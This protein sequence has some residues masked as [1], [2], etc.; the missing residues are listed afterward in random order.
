MFSRRDF[1][2][3]TSA[4]GLAAALPFS[5]NR[6]TPA[7]RAKRALFVYGGW[8]GHQPEAYRDRMV[9]RLET[10]GFEVTVSDTLDIYADA[11]L[12]GGLDV[13]VQQWT[14][15]EIGRAQ[16][17][18]LLQAVK[19]GVGI[20]GWHGGLGD[21]F[22]ANTDYQYMIG[23]QWV[24]HPGN[25]IDYTVHITDPNDPIT[26]GLS[27]FELKGTEQYYMHVDP[28]NHVLATTRFS[29]AHDPWID[30]AVVPVAW[31]KMFGRGRVFYSSI[32]HNPEDFDVPEVLELTMRG[33]RWAS[34]GR[35]AEPERLIR[36]VYD[37]G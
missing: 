34:E 24:A 6:P 25:R 32:G 35:T 8:P 17:Q 2:R 31:K 5:G 1:L 21:S 19:G 13:I 29:A 26:A 36:P 16:A 15:G 7:R 14:M 4:A 22:R 11:E 27:D 9:P 18:G 10:D 12:M 37:G 3:S 33:I 28:A 30:G 23:G 20:A